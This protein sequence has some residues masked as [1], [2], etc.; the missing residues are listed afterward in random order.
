MSNFLKIRPV[1]AGLLHADGRIDVKKQIFV[2]LRTRLKTYEGFIKT[3]FLFTSQKGQ[4]TQNL[5]CSVMSVS[6][7]LLTKWR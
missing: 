2:I 3:E 4:N 1:G 7:N 5:K 6:W